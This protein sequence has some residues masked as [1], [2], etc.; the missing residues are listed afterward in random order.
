MCYG[1]AMRKSA[2]LMSVIMLDG[3]NVASYG[4]SRGA[5]QRE[6]RGASSDTEVRNLAVGNIVHESCAH[7]QS[8]EGG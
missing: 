2:N 5:L 4:R 8:D 1:P 7:K 3:V 6:A